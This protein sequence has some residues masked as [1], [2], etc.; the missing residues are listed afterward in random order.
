MPNGRRRHSGAGLRLA[1]DA[2]DDRGPRGERIVDDIASLLLNAGEED[3]EFTLPD[4]APVGW[5]L[6][7]DTR[8]ADATDAVGWHGAPWRQH[9]PPGGPIGGPFPAAARRMT[10]PGAVERPGPTRGAGDG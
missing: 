7:F 6:M 10:R 8:A 1:G 2:I 9:L 3:V 5:R 4:H